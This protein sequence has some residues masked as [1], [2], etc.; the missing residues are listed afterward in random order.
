[1]ERDGAT[2]SLWQ[3]WD[4]YKPAKKSFPVDVVDVVV[5]GGGIT[6]LATALQ[7]QKGGMKCVLIES[8]TLGFGTTGGTTAHVN[9]IFDTS[10][11]DIE[12]DFGKEE[13]R[14]VHSAAE[15]ALE[16]FRSNIRE[17]NID[18]GFEL[19]DAYLFAKDQ[20][21]AGD[22]EKIVEA[23]QRAGLN[24]AFTG[25]IQINVPFEK[26][27]IIAQQA[28]F[29]PIRYIYG[30]AKAFEEAGGIILENCM[31]KSFDNGTP[32]IMKTNIGKIHTHQA[33]LAT[34]IPPGVNLLHFRCA[35][36]RSY[37]IAAKLKNDN[38][39]DSLIYDMDVPFHYYRTQVI[40]DQKY[41]I[42]GGEDHKT[43][44]DEDANSHLVNLEAYLRKQ[45]EIESITHRWSSQF[46]EPA[47]GL[48]YIGLLP[49]QSEN[50]YV[51]TGFSGN[52][53]TYSH[54]AANLLSELILNGKSIYAKLYDPGR[55]K[56]FAGFASFVSENVDV[57]KEFVSKRISIEKIESLN[58]IKKGEGRIVSF[59]GDDFAVYN[60]EGTLHAIDPVCTHAKC[61][62]QWN[63]AEETWD[64]PCHGARYS[65]DG[66]IL[67][68]P[69]TRKLDEVE[70]EDGTEQ[71]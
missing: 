40:G 31:L 48:A 26:A 16:T 67:T 17:H 69:T 5:V 68:G 47:D 7:L 46:Y 61:I 60:D 42:F 6:G 33:V 28:Q 70:I 9:T 22:L 64:C 15:M 14:L 25:D 35:P 50:I 10:Y 58:E 59:E 21:Q 11:H 4:S 2:K 37:V 13:A 30:L 12:N 66:E 36:Y 1:M 45:F 55:I 38:Y 19:K 65:I 27:A 57:V 49:G 20:K 43:G 54:I 3:D 34:H 52:G 63:N 29:H 44:H 8:H 24:I 23:S 53:M 39:P 56:P 41:L 32:A 62:V 71:V 18:C 51:A